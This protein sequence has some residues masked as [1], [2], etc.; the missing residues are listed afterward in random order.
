MTEPIS[1]LHLVLF[2]VTE[3]VGMKLADIVDMI[4][5]AEDSSEEEDDKDQTYKPKK[6]KSSNSNNNPVKKN[7]EID[8][9][10]LIK[11]CKHKQLYFF[12]Y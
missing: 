9:G 6:S 7:K 12:H 3:S 8:R 4:N 5:N 11:S 10:E 1:N 2:T